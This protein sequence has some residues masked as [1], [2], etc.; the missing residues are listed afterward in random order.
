M[1]IYCNCTAHEIILKLIIVTSSVIW[2][3]CTNNIHAAMDASKVTYQ[4]MCIIIAMLYVCSLCTFKVSKLYTDI[5][6]M[7][8]Y[9][10][11]Y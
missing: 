10:L 9:K 6:I 1:H 7:L 5:I 3:I 11:I 4:G 2:A 8:C